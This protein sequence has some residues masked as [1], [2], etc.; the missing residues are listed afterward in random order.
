VAK[1]AGHVQ[2]RDSKQN[3]TEGQLFLTFTPG[4]WTDFLAGLK[5]GYGAD[6][7]LGG[8]F[9]IQHN[10][11]R[12]YYTADEWAAFMDGVHKGEFDIEPDVDA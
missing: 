1:N 11:T 8:Q 6:L 7:L 5:L 4:E 3:G 2:V 9:M 12:L 10:H